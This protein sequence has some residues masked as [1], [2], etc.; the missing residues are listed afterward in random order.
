MIRRK[1]HKGDEAAARVFI[2]SLVGGTG[3]VEQRE[4]E[5]AW[6]DAESC[7][8]S[9]LTCPNAECLT[10]GERDCPHGESLHYHHDGCPACDVINSQDHVMACGCVVRNGEPVRRCQAHGG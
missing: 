9:A 6:P 10:C 3:A 7:T 5:G 1:P 8:G 2:Q 4:S